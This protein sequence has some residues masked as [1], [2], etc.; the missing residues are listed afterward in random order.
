[1]TKKIKKSDLKKQAITE[2]NENIE[3]LIDELTKEG[4]NTINEALSNAQES[5]V[6]RF[7][8]S[9]SLVLRQDD[10]YNTVRRSYEDGLLVI[11]HKDEIPSLFFRKN[12]DAFLYELLAREKESSEENILP[13][14]ESSLIG[15][16]RVYELE[17]KLLALAEKKDKYLVV[18]DSIP[19]G[20]G[21]LWHTQTFVL[22][23]PLQDGLVLKRIGGKTKYEDEFV[24]IKSDKS[25]YFKNYKLS[26]KIIA[27]PK[28][29]DD[30]E[31]TEKIEEQ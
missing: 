2:S 24:T 17:N 16:M 13:M 3:L 4:A 30:A 18:R 29:L 10:K 15:I 26:D 1:M 5:L 14:L 9:S 25:S 21:G 11:G 8:P 23:T 22:I 19:Y 12:G 7:V 27:A 6:L 31:D 28:L 20:I